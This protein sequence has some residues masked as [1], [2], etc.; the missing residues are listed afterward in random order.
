[1]QNDPLSGVLDLIEVRGVMS[2]GFAV[3]G[4]WIA[5]GA[6]DHPL[7]FI[8]V[9]RGQATVTADGHEEELLLDAG[10]VA[11][12]SHRSWLAVRGGPAGEDPV[13]I[14]V[15]R[16][17]FVSLGEDGV[18][19]VLGGHIDLNPLGRDLLAHTLPPV[20]V[21]RASEP[22]V[23]LRDRLVRLYTEVSG[24]RVG[25]AF[26]VRQHGQ[27]LLLDLLRLSI[28]QTDL[29]PGWLRVLTDERLR[30][31]VALIHQAPEKPW[32][33][34]T[35]ARAAAMSR[36]SFATL[37]RAAAGTPPLTYLNRWRILLAQRAL[38]TGDE[39]I[40]AIAST[41]GYASESAFSTAFKRGVG[42]SPLRYRNRVRGDHPRP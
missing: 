6:L 37:F 28:H 27:L 1:M 7:K 32:R 40:G 11:I 12:L 38:R 9:V 3:D 41:L 16:A 30:P 18:D 15:T 31:A 33:V 34:E 8:G 29:P 5:R 42:E 35:L 21:V 14:D 10:D 17:G 39:R 13:D 19:V 24:D 25:S 20:G 2:N 26:A 23:P 36:T 22:G 4:P